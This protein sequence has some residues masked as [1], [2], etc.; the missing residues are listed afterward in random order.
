[1]KSQTLTLPK[2]VQ[3][4]WHEVDLSKKP[5]G[6]AATEIANFLRGK[7]KRDFVPHV[8]M[9]DY[10][11]AINADNLQLSG[12]KVQQKLYFR[13]SGYLGG[14]KQ[15]ALKD[16]IQTNPE[17]VVKKAVFSMI[18]D[19]KFRKKIMSRLKIVKGSKHEYKV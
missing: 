14:I 1:M 19:L 5:L 10:V 18:D 4:K 13:H 2:K 15:T 9:G 8:D 11:V 16:L 3:R 17:E 6:R 7:H 12:R